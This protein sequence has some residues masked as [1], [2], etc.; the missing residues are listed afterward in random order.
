MNREKLVKTIKEILQSSGVKK[1]IF[2][3]VLRGMKK[4]ITI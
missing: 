2:S 1:P 4:N 3:A